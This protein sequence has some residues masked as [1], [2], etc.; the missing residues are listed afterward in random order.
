MN[1]I[2]YIL[3]VKNSERREHCEKFALKLF[4]L[5]FKE[6]EIMDAIYWKESDVISLLNDLNIESTNNVSQPQIACFL[7]HR[8]CWEIISSKENN[9]ND[10]HIILEDDMDIS[11]DL[12]IESLEKLYNSLK[13]NEYDSIFLYN[14]PEQSSNPDNLVLHNEFLYK[15]YFQWGTCGYS[16][17]PSFAKELC[18]FIKCL[19]NPIDLY[20][21]EELY[22]KHKKER[23][24]NSV[25]NYFIN[26]GFLG[27]NHK[28]F[29]F[30]SQIYQ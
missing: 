11:E 15:H 26:L 1:F 23:I 21:Q 27:G 12:S 3:S 30:K 22:E 20:L 19:S 2:A 25:K 14:H 8:K 16:I 5:G 18:S 29:R 6:V 28:E 24:F 4:N 10:I 7:T 13:E 17:I 9:P